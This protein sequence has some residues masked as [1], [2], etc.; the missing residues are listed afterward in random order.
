MNTD[1]RRLR[2]IRQ[3]P[4]V[5][6]PRVPGL[7]EEN[8]VAI[9]SGL[10]AEDANLLDGHCFYGLRIRGIVEDGVD[11]AAT[12]VPRATACQLRIS[13]GGCL[14]TIG[15]SVALAGRNILRILPVRTFW[16]CSR[17]T[18]LTRFF[19]GFSATILILDLGLWLNEFLHFQPDAN[20]LAHL[21]TT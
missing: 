3:R 2:R 10:S 14:S 13:S 8:G 1:K 5:Q 16:A 6:R 9:C 20:H 19:F 12:F 17:S 15:G 4:A 11:L 21:A 7:C 18:R